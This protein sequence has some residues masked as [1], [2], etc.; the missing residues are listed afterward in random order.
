MTASKDPELI[1]KVEAQG[2]VANPLPS[3]EFNGT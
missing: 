2:L 3:G 1:A